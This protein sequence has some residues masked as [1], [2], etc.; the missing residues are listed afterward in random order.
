MNWKEQE[1]ARLRR[2]IGEETHY[3]PL[4]ELRWDTNDAPARS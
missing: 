3:G 1:I 2:Q 4:G